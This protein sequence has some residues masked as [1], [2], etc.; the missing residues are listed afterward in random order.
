[1]KIKLCMLAVMMSLSTVSYAEGLSEASVGSVGYASMGGSS[2]IAGVALIPV[3]II[4]TPFMGPEALAAPS[5]LGG[6]LSV[7]AFDQAHNK[8]RDWEN[9]V[10]QWANE[11]DYQV[12]PLKSITQPNWE[13][14]DV[15]GRLALVSDFDYNNRRTVVPFVDYPKGVKAG[16]KITL[17]KEKDILIFSNSNN[18]V[19]SAIRVQ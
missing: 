2:I 3:G 10:E 4:L 8:Y 12:A 5:V 18:Q 19:V 1:M 9:G 17:K 7:L 6:W 15:N 14:R 13:V 11:N 16:D